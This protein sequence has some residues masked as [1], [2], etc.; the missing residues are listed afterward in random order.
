M[1][2]FSVLLM[3]SSAEATPPRVDW[4]ACFPLRHAIFSEFGR[5]R[6]DFSG[7]V[8]TERVFVEEWSA[9]EGRGTGGRVSLP[10][11]TDL[12]STSEVLFAA[13][14]EYNRGPGLTYEVVE[15]AGG[16]VVRPLGVER[17]FDTTVR[18]DPARFSTVG[19][20][21][22]DLK[23]QLYQKRGIRIGVDPMPGLR[24]ITPLSGSTSERTLLDAI[25]SIHRPMEE[26]ALSRQP[27]LDSAP[28]FGLHI[29]VFDAKNAAATQLILCEEPLLP[30]PQFL[31]TP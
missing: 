8:C 15:A 5:E 13:V 2:F 26:V 31:P 1:P 20:Q 24:E 11:P 6:R 16:W 9:C 30:Q 29:A 27:I 23:D 21:F 25:T 4:D 14:E 12:G 19:M 22:Q 17:V 3:T 28:R 7:G 10:L 18:L